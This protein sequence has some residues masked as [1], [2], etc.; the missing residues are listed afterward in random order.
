[1]KLNENPTV[2]VEN[3]VENYIFTKTEDMLNPEVTLCSI[4]VSPILNYVPKYFLSE[5]YSPACEKCEIS[6][7]ISDDESS[8]SEENMEALVIPPVTR[9]G[10]NHH[11]T[12]GASKNPVSYHCFHT[13]QCTICQP[14]PPPLPSLTPIV[15]EY[16]LYHSKVM[17]GELD[18]GST[19]WYCMR[20]D[21]D[22]YGCDSCVSIKHFGELHGYPDVNPSDYTKHL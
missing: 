17:A 19:C 8:L 22:N 5:R 1:M 16:S 12:F 15:N 6:S 10:F 2:T 13:R 14:F 18:W 21:C 11:P 4:C 20:I 3:N 9:R 7:K